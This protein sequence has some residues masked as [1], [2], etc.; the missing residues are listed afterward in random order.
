MGKF[1]ELLLTTTEKS[2]DELAQRIN[3]DL[4]RACPRRSGQAAQS[5][6]I[7]KPSRLTRF[8]GSSDEHLYFADQGNK[9]GHG[10]M[11]Y[12]VNAKALIITDK[13]GRAVA[14]RAHAHTYEGS[15]FVAKVAAKY[16]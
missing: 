14:F 4:K 9:P 11:I 8:I 5:I 1:A 6:H 3:F 15:H 10:G 7:E 13:S 12:P 16:R 2:L